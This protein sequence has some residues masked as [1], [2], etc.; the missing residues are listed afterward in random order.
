MFWIDLQAAGV[1]ETPR[2]STGNLVQPV[3]S[4]EGDASRPIENIIT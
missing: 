1:A 3:V 2:A 4:E